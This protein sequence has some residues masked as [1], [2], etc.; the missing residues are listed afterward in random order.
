M[1][2]ELMNEVMTKAMAFHKRIESSDH[3]TDVF[4]DIDCYEW[5]EFREVMIRLSI[6]EPNDQAQQR[7]ATRA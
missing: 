4:L 2:K 7:Y 6:L 5:H 3:L 1:D